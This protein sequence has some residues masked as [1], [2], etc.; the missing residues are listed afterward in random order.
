MFNLGSRAL[1]VTSALALV[2]SLF[3]AGL[4]TAGGFLALLLVRQGLS[5]T[6]VTIISASLAGALWLLVA[7]T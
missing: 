1:F 6:G 7:R 2:A 5:V 3:Y 4:S